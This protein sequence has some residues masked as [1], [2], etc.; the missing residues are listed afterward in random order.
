MVIGS[1]R[2]KGSVRPT[3]WI[4]QR[5][6]GH[7]AEAS[8]QIPSSAPGGGGCRGEPTGPGGQW[9]EVGGALV[10]AR[11]PTMPVGGSVAGA[12]RLHRDGP[13]GASAYPAS[14]R[15]AL[16]PTGSVPPTVRAGRRRRGATRRRGEV[17]APEWRSGPRETLSVG[18]AIGMPQPYGAE[19][20]AAAGSRSFSA[21]SV[22]PPWGCGLPQR[23]AS[24]RRRDAV[25][26]SAERLAAVRMSCPP[27]ARRAAARAAAAR[28]RTMR[29][30]GGNG[31]VLPDAGRR[32]T[33][34]SSSPAGWT[35]LPRLPNALPRSPGGM[36]VGREG[37]RRRADGGRRPS[38]TSPGLPDNPP[39]QPWN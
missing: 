17:S 32:P 18:A 31:C 10:S 26:R 12:V 2:M 33:A 8:R 16:P 4:E 25:F 37:P 7:P 15:D 36:P 30:R 22:S 39:P 9:V 5:S 34:R 38:E 29:M 35:W 1:S 27:Q 23:G 14:G 13:P 19:G 3:S 24:R 20:L 28:R 6:A 11:N 21:R